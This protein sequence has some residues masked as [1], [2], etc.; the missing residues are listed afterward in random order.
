VAIGA[1]IFARQAGVAAVGTAAGTV[2]ETVAGKLQK[3][4]EMNNIAIEIQVV[5]ITSAILIV[6]YALEL[7]LMLSL[8][9]A[10]SNLRNVRFT[11][12]FL[13][14][15]YLLCPGLAYLLTKIIPLE[16]P[17]AIGMILVG[18]A[19]CSAF[20]PG[21]VKKARGDSSCAESSMLALV[22][23]VLYMP[24]VVPILA[25]G[26]AAGAESIAKVLLVL[27]PGPV[28]I[29]LAVKFATPRIS[30][31]LEPFVKK[32]VRYTTY[33]LVTLVL[34]TSVYVLGFLNT[35][36]GYA[37]GTLV[38][39]VLVSSTGSYFLSPGLEQHQK[40]VLSLGMSNRSIAS[41][42][43]PLLVAG[44]V[45]RRAMVM[46]ML[47]FPISIGLSLLAAGQFARRVPAGDATATDP[48]HREVRSAE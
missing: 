30:R 24:L 35:I 8:R 11:G 2:K 38:V 48:A 28:A 10:L 32:T 9:T 15:G 1:K 12:L 26:L 18:L 4:L 22:L 13:I 31:A 45:D 7:G 44:N 3:V 14:W 46:V 40:S 23:T 16:Q 25:P 41:A 5:N 37:I 27:V 6:L 19:P 17:Y 29:G 47:A 20:L 21:M 34:S 36:G 33:F 42:F 39:F 43:A